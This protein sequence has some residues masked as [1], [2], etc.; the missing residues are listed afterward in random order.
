MCALI[1][2][3][4]YGVYSC[5]RGGVFKSTDA[6]MESSGFDGNDGDVERQ[7]VKKGPMVGAVDV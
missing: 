7:R 5:R 3:S 1:G 2:W 6:T 4:W